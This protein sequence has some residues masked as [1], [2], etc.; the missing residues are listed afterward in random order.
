MYST[1]AKQLTSQASSLISAIY[2]F[3]LLFQRSK[4]NITA[5]LYTNLSCL[6][7]LYTSNFVK[8]EVIQGAADDLTTIDENVLYKK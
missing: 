1:A 5:E 3:N 6:T 2:R 4:R 8:F 7:H